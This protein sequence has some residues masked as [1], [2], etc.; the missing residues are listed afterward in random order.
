M[1]RTKDWVAV[2]LVT[3]LLSFLPGCANHE[4]KIKEDSESGLNASQLW[5][6]IEQVEFTITAPVRLVISVDGAS[7]ISYPAQQDW[8]EGRTSERFPLPMGRSRYTL[9][10]A[11]TLFDGT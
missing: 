8:S 5:L 10:F 3:L 2:L 4:A 11:A 9:R 7:N 1:S 6:I